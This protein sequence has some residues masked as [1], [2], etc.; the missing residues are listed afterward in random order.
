MSQSRSLI[1]ARLRRVVTRSYAAGPR[2]VPAGAA[3]ED[4]KRSCAR[5][6]GWRVR[7]LK[8]VGRGAVQGPGVGAQAAAFRS[9]LPTISCSVS[10][11][12][13]MA[14]QLRVFLGFIVLVSG[15]APPRP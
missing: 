13:A 2:R 5:R 9:S 7:R 3:L 10:L 1:T 15:A 6:N 4:L 12:L 11:R 8:E 14:Y